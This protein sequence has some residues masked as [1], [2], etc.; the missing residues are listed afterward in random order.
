MG[1]VKLITVIALSL[2][3]FSPWSPLLAVIVALAAAVVVV[4]AGLL[5]GR[6]KLNATLPLGPYLLVG[7]VVASI[8]L[9]AGAF[10]PETQKGPTQIAGRPFAAR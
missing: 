1:D 7:F 5:A 4:I 6:I 8:V 9:G 10:A 2:G 3:W